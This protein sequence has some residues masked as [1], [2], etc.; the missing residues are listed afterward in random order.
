METG[1]QNLS[2]GTAVFLGVSSQITTESWKEPFGAL[3]H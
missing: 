1:T 3:S 2:L